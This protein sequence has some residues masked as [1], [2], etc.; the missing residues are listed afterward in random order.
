MR[1]ARQARASGPEDAWYDV[2]GDSMGFFLRPGDR[3]RLVKRP[4]EDLRPGEVVV[5][6][7]PEAQGPGAYVVHRLLWKK[8]LAG[9]WRLWTRGD[10]SNDWDPPLWLPLGRVVE[11][12]RDGARWGCAPRWF[13]YGG[14]LLALYSWPLFRL[15]RLGARVRRR[16]GGWF[17]EPA[18]SWAW[19]G[20]GPG[21]ILLR[22]CFFWALPGMERGRRWGWRALAFP[23][24]LFLALLRAADRRRPETAA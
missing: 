11:M 17:L 6:F 4:A 10:W 8:R 19:A 9:G 16:L 3:I 22:R 18:L 13:R 2:T 1:A 20:S 21:R 15:G 5:L 24:D 12:E 14:L 23:A 7:N